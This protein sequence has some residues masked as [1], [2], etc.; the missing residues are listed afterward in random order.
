MTGADATVVLVH[1]PL[2]GAA[3][4]GR[5]PDELRR[6]GRDVVVVEVLDDDTAPFAARFVARASLQVAAALGSG[7]GSGSGTRSD[8]GVQRPVVLVGHSGAGYLLPLLAAARRSAG[9]SVAAYVFLDAG[10]P[11]ARPS[12]RHALMRA[13]SPAYADEVE[14]LL[15]RGGRF[16]DW[17]DA[18]LRDL[19]PDDGSR[20][21]LVASLRPRGRD[22]FHEPLPVATDWPDAPCGYLQLSGSYAK[23][24]ALARMRG[25]LVTGGVERPGGHLA[26]L[27][28]PCGVADDLE[29][30]IQQL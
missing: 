23:P 25:W 26:A 10:L 13:E 29:H 17:D 27:V 30:L 14:A 5:L 21:A 3:A 16:P 2:T 11:P 6:R 19:V 7:T 9:G 20:A 28:D 12:S 8:D 15:D 1:S 22:F 18:S 24:A 4:F